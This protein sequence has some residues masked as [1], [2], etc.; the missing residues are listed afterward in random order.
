[1]TEE[2]NTPLRQLRFTLTREDIAAYELLPRELIGLEKLWLVGPILVCG[3]LVGLFQDNLKPYFPWDPETQLGQVLSVLTAV[4]VGYVLSLIAL[5]A[6]ARARI[7]RAPLPEGPT[8]IDAYPQLLF[9]GKG[10]DQSSYAWTK[11]NVVETAT[12]VFLVETGRPPVILPLRAFAN[13]A[14]MANFAALARVMGRDEAEEA[15]TSGPD[16][17]TATKE[18][19]R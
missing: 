10:G 2:L 18:D 8:T 16:H 5:T 14:D 17:A 11:L 1:M 13:A 19:S 9:A 6:R 12:H 3:A 15:G 7:A 4:A